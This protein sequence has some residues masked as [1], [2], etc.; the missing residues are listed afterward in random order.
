[1]AQARRWV[2][3]DFGG[4]EV[5][6]LVTVELPEP[7]PGEVTIEVRAAGMKPGR[8]Q[9]VRPRRPGEPAPAGRL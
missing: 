4:P 3:T 5:L 9:G 6:D 2:A 1:L 7:G 8:L